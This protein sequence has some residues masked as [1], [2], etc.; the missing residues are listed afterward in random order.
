MLS[1]FSIRSLNMLFMV[2]LNSPCDNSK[3]GA[4]FS[5]L[6]Y[7]LMVCFFLPFVKLCHSAFLKPDM[8]QITNLVNSPQCEYYVNLTSSWPGFN[9]CY[10]CDYL[11]LRISLELLFSSV[12]LTLGLWKYF[13]P[14]KVYILLFF[15]LL[16][17]TI[18]LELYWYGGRMDLF[19][20]IKS[21]PVSG[22]VSVL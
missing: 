7:L 12:L 20:W 1:P 19:F 10:S 4:W 22:P 14:K 21:Q 3:M 13:F 11:R 8:Y 6:P 5:C 2:I 16:F 18:I 17:I 15:L 9:V